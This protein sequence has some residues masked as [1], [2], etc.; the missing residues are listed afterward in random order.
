[1]LVALFEDERYES[2]SPASA[3][4]PVYWMGGGRARLAEALVARLGAEKAALFMRKELAGLYKWKLELLRERARYS[5]GEEVEEDLLLVNGRLIPT[6]ECVDLLRRLAEAG[7]NVLAFSGREVVAIRVQRETARALREVYREVMA[8][9]ALLNL[10]ESV[11]V[12]EARGCVLARGP[13]DLLRAI[14]DLVSS[15]SGAEEEGG[16]SGEV[17]ADTS[18]G[19]VVV[20]EGAVVEPYSVLVGPC[21]VGRGALVE[22]GSR[23]EE[24]VVGEGSLISGKVRKS[25]LGDH[26]VIRGSVA[27]SI[28]SDYAYVGE[29]AVL[30]EDPEGGSG[31]HVL[32]MGAKVHACS[33]LLPYR[34]VG[35]LSEVLGFLDR[36]LGDFASYYLGGERV[37]SLREALAYIRRRIWKAERRLP[38]DYEVELLEALYSRR[39]RHSGRS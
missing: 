32:G 30:P 8:A 16:L 3:T 28:I 15:V 5:V 2:F 27:R 6:A 24:S 12:V 25:I 37:R 4:S 23:I 13:E 26:V 18:R 14:P 35:A 39:A 36:D 21:Y 22:C 9:D 10:L 1:M 38:S 31:C 34:R 33:A 17:R 19:P 7:G 29:G 11:Q 20:E